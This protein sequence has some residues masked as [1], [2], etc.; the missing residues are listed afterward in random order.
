[1]STTFKFDQE[2]AILS[3]KVV[4]KNLGGSLNF[5]KLFKILYFA[6]QKHLSKYGRPIFADIYIAMKDGPVPSSIYDIL[7]IIKG[8]G[9]Y[10]N[11]SLQEFFGKIFSVEEYKV[12]LKDQTIDLDIFSESELECIAAS[13]EENKLLGYKP[14][15]HKSHDFAWENSGRN[16]KIS[17]LDIAKAGGANDELLKYITLNIENE[18][19][20]LK[21]ALL[22]DALPA[23]WRENLAK[24]NIKSGAVIRIAVP[25]TTP[26]KIKFLL[27]VGLEDGKALLATVFINTEINPNVFNTPEL[28][29]LQLEL[30]KLKCPYLG[31][32]SYADCSKIRERNYI[33]ILELIKKTPSS[34]LGQ[35]NED[36]F[37]KVKSLIK[38]SKTISIRLKKKYNL[39]Y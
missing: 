36:D 7:K 15:A 32:D 13:I 31:H 25:D 20:N 33:D 22:G 38:T 18:H 24:E 29:K 35:L 12:Q 39:F 6:E 10:Y 3:I 2:K 8:A 1:M 27:I 9:I 23:E 30:T 21:W 34:H 11:E 19:F 17:I 28:Q 16:Q 5:H 14:L 37:Q 26:P 4:L